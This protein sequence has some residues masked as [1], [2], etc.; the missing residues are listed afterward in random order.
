MT[1]LPFAEAVSSPTFTLRLIPKWTTT[2]WASV[3]S[4]QHLRFNRNLI[5]IHLLLGR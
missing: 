2:R 4:L 1:I 3:H 5:L